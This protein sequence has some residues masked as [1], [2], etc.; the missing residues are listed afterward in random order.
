[1]KAVSKER[2]AAGLVQAAERARYRNPESG[3]RARQLRKAQGWKARNPEKI[4]A[5]RVVEAAIARGE[6]VRQP[7]EVCGARAQAHHADYGRPL[8]VQWLCPLHH[9]RQHVAEGRMR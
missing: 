7:C 6:L 9:A 8:A 3:Y 1:M 5:H 2:R 4:Q